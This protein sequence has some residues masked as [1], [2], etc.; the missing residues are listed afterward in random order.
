MRKKRAISAS[1]PRL[2]WR[3]YLGLVS[4]A[5]CLPSVAFASEE[6]P[7]E[8]GSA[9]VSHWERFEVWADESRTFG[10]DLFLTE[11]QF[12]TRDFNT[13]HAMGSARLP[14]GLNIWGFVDFEA[15]EDAP[16]TRG[17]IAKFFYEIDLR[18]KVWNDFGLIAEVNEFAGSD[19]T[20]GRFGLFYMP[21]FDWLKEHSLFVLIKGFPIETDKKGGQ[22]SLA[23]N[24]SFPNILGG[25]ISIGGFVDFNFDSGLTEDETN[26][27][28]E[29]QL[30]V[31][32]LG[33]LHAI[34]EVRL[35]QFLLSDQDLGVGLGVQYRF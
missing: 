19:N 7:V 5:V 24:K 35:N 23:L 31:R 11:Y 26:V 15:I 32:V 2:S 9:P 10:K 34:A 21:T 14:A 4:F 29:W 20:L 1:E 3:L 22:I 6:E 16:G 27:L 18:R 17:D 28:T 33:G 13:F 25:R 12:D 8:S 30:R